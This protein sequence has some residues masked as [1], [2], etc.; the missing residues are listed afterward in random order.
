MTSSKSFRRGANLFPCAW[1]LLAALFSATFAKDVPTCERPPNTD[2]QETKLALHRLVQGYVRSEKASYESVLRDVNLI[3]GDTFP[4]RLLEDVVT[5]AFHDKTQ[6]ADRLVRDMLETVSDPDCMSREF[7]A[8]TTDFDA[9]EAANILQNCKLLVIRNVFNKEFMEEYKA[10]VTGYIQ[11][12]KN[13]EISSEGTTSN[14]EN[15]FQQM[16]DI[17]RWEV[18]LPSNLAHP[19]IISNINVMKVLMDERVLGSELVVHSLGTTLVDSGAEAQDWHTDSDY[20]F[21]DSLYEAAGISQHQ[22]PAYAITMV[23]P[24]LHMTPD[25]GPMQFSMGSSNLAGLTESRD[26]IRFQDESLRSHLQDQPDLEDKDDNNDYKYTRT[27]LLALGDVVLF[28]YQ[29]INRGGKNTSPD[30]CT[31]LYSTYSRP[32]YKDRGFVDIDDD[33]L[34]EEDIDSDR[35][36]LINLYKQLTLTARFAIPENFEP[37]EE[38]EDVLSTDWRKYGDEESTLEALGKFNGG[39]SEEAF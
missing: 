36:Q 39:W 27:P 30:L 34:D 26:E 32:W 23:A 7:D 20:L 11:G 5:E 10:N 8:S 9:A 13:G 31:M 14:N 17:G 6:Y 29:L 37:N 33:I 4:P 15:H 18:L 1:I 38:Y 2:D 16:L 19:R 28:D 25:H 12:L 21:S 3:V 24:L 35:A 22:V